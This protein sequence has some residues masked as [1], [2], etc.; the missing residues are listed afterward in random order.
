MRQESPGAAGPQPVRQR[1]EDL[2]PRVL[3]W[4]PT[5][6]D[7]RNQWKQNLPL[8]IRKIRRVT[9]TQPAHPSPQKYVTAPLPGNSSAG[10]L[11]RRPLVLPFVRSLP[12]CGGRRPGP[13]APGPAAVARL[14]SVVRRPVLLRALPTSAPAGR[15]PVQRPSTACLGGVNVLGSEGL[16]GALPSS[17]SSRRAR[18]RTVG[19]GPR[20]S[21]ARACWRCSTTN[22][23]ACHACH[24]CHPGNGEPRRETN[25]PGFNDRLST[26]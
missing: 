13:P 3:R 12:S 1:V 22:R 6:L 14:R 17:T 26:A 7:R 20:A 21:A 23:P 11:F 10:R 9:G 8:R 5:R 25:A 24:A 2:P 16:K 19:G 18:A 4:S 15:L